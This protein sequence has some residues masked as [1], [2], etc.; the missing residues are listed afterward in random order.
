MLQN[1]TEIYIEAV[2]EPFLHS[3]RLTRLAFGLV[4]RAQVMSCLPDGVHGVVHLDRPLLEGVR[5]CFRTA[6]IATMPAVGLPDTDDQELEHALDE[7]LAAVDASPHPAG[8]WAPARDLLDD[9]LLARILGIS[10][11]SLR[12]Y[13]SGAR[14]TPDQIAWRLHVVA[15]MLASLLGSY[16]AYGVRRWFERPRAMLEGRTPAQVIMSA[17]HEEDPALGVVFELSDALV[18]AGSAT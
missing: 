12:R 18:G 5:T 16:N 13:A 1:M 3:P 2:E 14:E 10:E 4:A 15:R 7:T 8:E 11:S 6:G 17:E 9:A